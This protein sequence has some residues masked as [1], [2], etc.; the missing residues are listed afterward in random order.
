MLRTFSV[1]FEQVECPKAL[2]VKTGCLRKDERDRLAFNL[3]NSSSSSPEHTSLGAG[4]KTAIGVC[5][6][7]FLV[8]LT[9]VAYC[10]Y[11]RRKGPTRKTS[12]ANEKDF[13]NATTTEPELAARSENDVLPVQELYPTDI[14]EA[15]ATNIHELNAVLIHEIEA[16]LRDWN[17]QRDR[18][19]HGKANKKK[20]LRNL[21]S[22]LMGSSVCQE[23]EG[24]VV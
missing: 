6:P 4:P 8:V 12:T 23:L 11:K 15:A 7:V 13:P 3:L 21:P 18:R 22:E 19:R 9:C 20:P 16:S 10:M 5:I 2:T 17:S 1:N 24:H 14:Q